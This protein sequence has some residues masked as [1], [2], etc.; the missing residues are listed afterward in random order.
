MLLCPVFATQSSAPGWYFAG[1]FQLKGVGGGGGGEAGWPSRPL[2]TR[3]AWR[4]HP[5]STAV[6]APASPHEACSWPEHLRSTLS[7]RVSAR[8]VLRLFVRA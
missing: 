4:N 1:T 8:S 6:C 2:K 5:D 3:F 7:L